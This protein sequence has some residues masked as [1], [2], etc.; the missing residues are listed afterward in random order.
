MSIDRAWSCV[1][2]PDQAVVVALEREKFFVR[3]SFGDAAFAAARRAFASAALSN[4]ISPQRL[5]RLEAA[6]EAAPSSYE[7]SSQNIGGSLRPSFTLFHSA[8]FASLP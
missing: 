5:I 4:I 1:T 6:C 7:F 2:P 3:A 8:F